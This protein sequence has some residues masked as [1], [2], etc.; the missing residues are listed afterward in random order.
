MK[1]REGGIVHDDT[2]RNTPLGRQVTELAHLRRIRASKMRQQR[3]NLAEK[4]V[5]SPDAG[6]GRRMVEYR[7]T[8]KEGRYAPA[9]IL[10]DD[11]NSSG[12]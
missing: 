5:F 3:M 7:Q 12:S 8:Y 2:H 6:H 9:R 1:Q 10:G 4:G 11:R